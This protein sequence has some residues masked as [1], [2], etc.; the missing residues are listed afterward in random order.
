MPEKAPE[1][2]PVPSGDQIGEVISFFAVPSAAILKIEKGSL[3]IG[4]SIWIRGHTTDLKETVQSMQVEHQA[5]TQAE[6]GTEV[7]VK[8]SARVRRGDRVYKL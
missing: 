6:K 2:G 8:V 4:D 5:I 7:G 3:K 1:S